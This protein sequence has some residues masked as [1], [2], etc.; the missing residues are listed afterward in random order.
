MLFKDEVL[1]GTSE[2]D[3]WNKYCG[4]LTLSLNEFME[5]QERLLLEEIELIEGTLIGK[6]LLGEKV[7]TSVE[8][9]RSNTPLTAYEDYA[10]FLNEQKEEA[11][12]EKP[13]CW[14]HTS[15]R[16]GLFKWIPYT[17]RAYE[18]LGDGEVTALLL[19][20]ARREG[21]IRA[22]PGDRGVYNIPPRPYFS[23]VAAYAGAERMGLRFI[24][25]LELSENMEF[26]ERIEAGFRMAL[27]TGVDYLG[28][29][30][31]VLVRIGE[32][33]TEQSG[34]LKFSA[35]MLH[36]SVLL[37]IARAMILSRI[38]KRPML[39]KDLWPVR[40]IICS[41]TDT[42]IYRN[43]VM[44]YWGALP[45]ELYACTEGGLMAF[46][47][48][49]KKAM[50]FVP[51]SVFLEFIPEDEWLK[52]RKDPKYCPSTV[53]IDEV[54]AGKRYE[55]VFTSFYGMP[56]LRYRV[57]DLIRIV[58]LQDES[59]RISLPQMLFESRADDLIDLAGFTRL[60]EKTVWQAIVNSGLEYEDWTI[61][62]EFNGGRPFL[63]LYLELK[64]FSKTKRAKQ[65]IDKSLTSL[66]PDYADLIKILEVDPLR[67]TILPKGSFQRYL[68]TKKKAGFDLAH[69]KPPHMNASDKVIETLLQLVHEDPA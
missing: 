64:N 11:L 66:D 40:A 34:A 51:Y 53:L 59:A 33:F 1:H 17:K 58:S 37:R 36:P 41:G 27:R 56:F 50:T 32:A 21:E 52:N 4:F 15:G 22:K 3:I 14:A 10:P 20:A 44:Y 67:L 57:G 16:S 8:E 12:S 65:L 39:P 38:E 62:K 29:M 25:P 60:D 30:T 61:R 2:S 31:S 42:A 6:K 23:G 24:P 46:Q 55:L 18:I 26:Q 49:N 43:R 9:F 54:E 47:S 45:Y 13:V 28:S 69:L 5:I 35:S 68:E 48:W 63:H 7:P 19:A